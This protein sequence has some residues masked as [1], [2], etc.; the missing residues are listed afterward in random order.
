MRSNANFCVLP[1]V[2]F[3]LAGF[4]FSEKVQTLGFE[5]RI[6]TFFWILLFAWVANFFVIM[7]KKVCGYSDL[8]ATT[9]LRGV[10]SG[11]SKWD[12][13]QIKHKT[14]QHKWRLK[15][16]LEAQQNKLRACVFLTVV[17]RGDKMPSK[18]SEGEQNWVSSKR[19]TSSYNETRENQVEQESH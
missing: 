13:Q 15:C 1:S 2:V 8:W 9:V 5:L 12:A 7:K 3:S 6:T 10:L 19:K 17:I 16:R 14:D 18:A 4:H 11:F